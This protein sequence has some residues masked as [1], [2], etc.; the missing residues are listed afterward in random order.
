LA[1]FCD[2]CRR[3]RYIGLC[4]SPPG[5]GKTLSAQYSANWFRL[6]AYFRSPLPPETD[7]AAVAGST[8]GRVESTCG[9]CIES[10]LNESSCSHCASSQASNGVCIASLKAFSQSV[11]ALLPL[12]CT[13]IALVQSLPY[14]WL[15][16]RGHTIEQD[17]SQAPDVVG[18]AGGHRG[19]PLLP[20]LD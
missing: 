8:T 17:F 11:D 19:R 10:S 1:E 20:A 9:Y 12:W 2:A 13:R 3:D 6:E 16:P 7:M 14:L 18:H 15:R 5:V 4:Y